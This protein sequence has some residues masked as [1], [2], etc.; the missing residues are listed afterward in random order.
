MVR[1]VYAVFSKD[2]KDAV[3]WDRLGIEI[4]ILSISSIFCT[5]F[6]S[7]Y[8]S[9]FCTAFTSRYLSIF[10]TA[11]VSCFSSIFFNFEVWFLDCC[12]WKISYLKYLILILEWKICYFSLTLNLFPYCPIKRNF[13]SFR[14]FSRTAVDPIY[15]SWSERVYGNFKN[16]ILSSPK[17][18]II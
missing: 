1:W 16:K 17:F 14:C 6:V 5:A 9:I 15:T 10:C 13:F 8:L 11:F 3:H 2:F 4:T 18:E 12:M 7:C